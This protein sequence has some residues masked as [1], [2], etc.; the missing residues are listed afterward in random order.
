MKIIAV[1]FA[2]FVLFML[3]ATASIQLKPQKNID[4]VTFKW[5]GVKQYYTIEI[6]NNPEFSSPE[7]T[8]EVK[9]RFY[10]AKLSPGIWYWK[11]DNNP[12]KKLVVD[13]IVALKRDD[14]K[15]TNDGNVPVKITASGFTG[16]SI[17]DVNESGKIG[18][19]IN[20]TA[21]SI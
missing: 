1:S 10:N 7:F 17:L 4:Y 15:I 18:G 19:L 20:V 2:V 6:D 13:S 9:S 16:L 8:G 14:E 21:E 12:S 11:I 3:A 5:I